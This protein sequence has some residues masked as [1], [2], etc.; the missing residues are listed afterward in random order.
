MFHRHESARGRSAG[1]QRASALVALAAAASLALTACA[2]PAETPTEAP[3]LAADQ[4]LRFGISGEPQDVKVGADQGA[5]GYMLNSLIH[6]GLVAYDAAGEIIPALAESYEAIDAANY[7]FTLREGLTFSDGTPLTSENVKNTLLF[8]S[9]PANGA[10][11]LAAMRGIEDVETPDDRTVIVHLADNNAE[12][13]YYLADSTAFIA[14]D[15]VLVAGAISTIGAGPFVIEKDEA[16]VQLELVK[17]EAYY[18]AANVTLESLD[19]VFY[20]DGTARTN[21]LVSGDVDLIDYV[22]WEQFST[23]EATPGV[24]IDVQ[25]GLMMDVEFNV[26]SGPFAD[27][28]VREAV[29]Y[30]INRDNVVEAAFFGN[31]K[32]VYGPPIPESSEYYTE[33]SQNLWSYDPEHAKELLAEAGYPDGFSATILTTSQYI[34]H[35]DT[36]LT[37]QADLAAI[38]IDTTLDSP[39]WPTR[40][41]KATSGDY[42]IKVGGWGGIVPEPAYLEFHLAGPDLA[43]S[44]GWSDPELQAALE[45]GRTGKDAEARKAG[46]ADAFEQ[47]AEK[48]PFIP[49]VQRGQAFA[50][51]ET[52]SGFANLPG[53]LTFFSGYTFTDTKITAG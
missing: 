12:F 27:P 30:A 40:M 1:R 16:G 24:T 7:S 53:F 11:T 49:L 37:V 5:T 10:R 29:A 42:Q 2:A 14:P 35:Q 21:A 32:A 34:F 50:Y 47:V 8:L 33:E 3:E 48:A 6:R 45:E 52:V 41:A 51:N 17:N 26:T 39:D 20:P 36:A 23:L 4:A 13:L 28:L 9:D 25:N 46:Y 18:D 15:D 43:K 31:A 38:G 44:F 19:L 22:P